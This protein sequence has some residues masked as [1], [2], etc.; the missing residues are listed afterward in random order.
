MKL[1]KKS[2]DE[3]TGKTFLRLDIVKKTTHVG[4]PSLGNGSQQLTYK[5]LHET[6]QANTFPYGYYMFSW[7]H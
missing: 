3:L 2:L 5:S 7:Y 1:K 4:L 6:E